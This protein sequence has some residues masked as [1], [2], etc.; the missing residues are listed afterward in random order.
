MIRINIFKMLSF[1]LKAIVRIAN[2]ERIIIQ[3]FSGN[4]KIQ[5]GCFSGMAFRFRNTRLKQHIY[6]KHFINSSQSHFINASN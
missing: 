6:H 1:H 4:Q 5:T 2:F 3:V